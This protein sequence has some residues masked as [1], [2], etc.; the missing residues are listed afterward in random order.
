MEDYNSDFLNNEVEQDFVFRQCELIFKHLNP[1]ENKELERKIKTET[2]VYTIQIIFNNYLYLSFQEKKKSYY[3]Q[4]S[5]NL[6]EV[7]FQFEKDQKKKIKKRKK[8]NKMDNEYPL[9]VFYCR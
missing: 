8:V 5:S 6:K 7:N 1:K 2:N 9:F 3:Y 4:K